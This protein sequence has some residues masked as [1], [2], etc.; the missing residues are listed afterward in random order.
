[1]TALQ[2]ALTTM[3]PQTCLR[4]TFAAAISGNSLP[5]VRSHAS[6]LLSASIR[7]SR[8]GKLTLGRVPAKA[9]FVRSRLL[10][11]FRLL[12]AVSTSAISPAHE[13]RFEC[14]SQT[15]CAADKICEACWQVFASCWVRGAHV[16]YPVL[17]TTSSAIARSRT[18]RNQRAYLCAM[19]RSAAIAGQSHCHCHR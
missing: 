11:C 3:Q 8:V 2:P 14:E 7:L 4:C 10:S 13:P 18:S 12:A 5:N 17:C 9:C 16:V 1:M 15:N 6:M 19:T